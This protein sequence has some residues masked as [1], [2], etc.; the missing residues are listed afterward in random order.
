[1]G[2]G[3]AWKLLLLQTVKI[4]TSSN[5]TN[6]LHH[7]TLQNIVAKKKESAEESY[8]VEN[9]ASGGHLTFTSY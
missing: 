5:K 9:P 3:K 8:I 6:D 2:G 4:L 7:A 1:M